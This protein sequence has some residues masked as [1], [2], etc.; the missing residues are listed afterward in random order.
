MLLLLAAPSFAWD[1]YPRFEVFGGYNFVRA[2]GD[3]EWIAGNED[4]K[5][6]KGWN[7]AI[8]GNLSPTFGIKAEFAGVYSKFE[9]NFGDKYSGMGHSVMAGPHFRQQINGPVN[10]FGHALFGYKRLDNKLEYSINWDDI[11]TTTN[12]FSMAFGGGVDWNM[13][14]LTIRLPQIDYFPWINTDEVL[15]NFRLSAGVVLKF[16]RKY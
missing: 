16:G 1:E 11:K 4:L 2:L 8:T 6:M 7:M 15:N 10:L 12:N 13:G 5:N 9:D 14:K 3:G